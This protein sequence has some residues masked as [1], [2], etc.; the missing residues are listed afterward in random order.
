MH[1]Y[2]PSILSPPRY[3]FLIIMGQTGTEDVDPGYP[4]PEPSGQKPPMP[5][6]YLIHSMSQRNWEFFMD[7]H[8]DAV[9][10]IKT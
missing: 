8:V 1:M 7:L 9:A 5:S 3:R 4:T 10:L 2:F 6:T